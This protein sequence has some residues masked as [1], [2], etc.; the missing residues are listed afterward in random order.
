MK[1]IFSLLLTCFFGSF[2]FSQYS[3][4]DAKILGSASGDQFVKMTPDEEG[5]TFVMANVSSNASG[6]DLNIAQYGFLDVWLLKLDSDKNIIW[7]KSYGGDGLDLG[8]E[9]KVLP[10]G[11][12]LLFIRSNS[13]LSGNRTAS[14]KGSG[15]DV[16]I[17]EIDSD[18]GDIIRQ[19]SIGGDGYSDIY[20]DSKV[21][22]NGDIVI[23]CGTNGSGSGNLDIDEPP[24]NAGT[25]DPWIAV[26]DNQLNITQ[27]KRLIQGEANGGSGGGVGRG[28]LILSNNYIYIAVSSIGNSGGYKSDDSFDPDSTVPLSNDC[29]L[30]KM[31]WNFNV[32]WDKTFGGKSED[33]VRDILKTE[34]GDFIILLN[35]NSDIG[36][37]KVSPRIGIDYNTW[38]IKVDENGNKINDKTYGNS[39]ETQIQT[40]MHRLNENSF[41]F[42]GFVETVN[43]NDFENSSFYGGTYDG[44]L[45]AIDKQLNVK[46]ISVF[47]TP[48]DENIVSLFYKNGKVTTGGNSDYSGTSTYHPTSTNGSS[49]LWLLELSTSLSITNEEIRD[50]SIF[51]NPARHKL[52]IKDADHSITGFSVY[53][54]LGKQVLSKE[55]TTGNHT[56]Q[57][58]VQDF[59]TGVYFLNLK[60][61]NGNSVRKKFVVE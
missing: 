44:F 17:V 48:A 13:D 12:V 52:T 57:I 2:T 30:I 50:V 21:R 33:E 7:Q 18:N 5:N 60:F 55:N 16:W 23:L 20:I 36:G 25:S 58:N 34:D 1:I 22:A 47:G 6:G 19:R 40:K 31:D 9:I 56:F 42:G 59:D 38:L 46:D 32:I 61:K 35:S 24:L 29:W 4:V 37:N 28:A 49:D 26:L 45:M 15:H 41:V 53:N 11:N 39:A 3:L 51:P 43:D 14:L 54:P 10:N 27:Q 8:N